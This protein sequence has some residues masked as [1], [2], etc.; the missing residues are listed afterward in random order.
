VSAQPRNPFELAEPCRLAGARAIET[1]NG[2]T[3]AE[4]YTAALSR[5]QGVV[6]SFVK[7]IGDD[8]EAS[9]HCLNSYGSTL[10]H[11]G[12]L[13][14]AN[15]VYRQATNIAGRTFGDDDDATLTL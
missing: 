13:E 9:L 4:D 5:L 14:K 2:A 3:A 1:V 6:D 8:E 7:K 10:L 11:L 15:V 12:E